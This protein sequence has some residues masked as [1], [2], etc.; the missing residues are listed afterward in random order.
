MKKTDYTAVTM[1]L[2]RAEKYLPANFKKKMETARTDLV[3]LRDKTTMLF[4]QAEEYE[5]SWNTLKPLYEFIYNEAVAENARYKIDLK[6][7]SIVFPTE[8]IEDKTRYATVC[9]YMCMAVSYC[10]SLLLDQHEQVDLQGVISLVDE[11]SAQLSSTPVPSIGITDHIAN[12]TKL[13]SDEYDPFPESEKGKQV[14]RRSGSSS[15]VIL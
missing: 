15:S 2:I 12:I 4:R 14:A 6:V 3:L 8:T 1:S 10:K 7:P 9:I 11:Y 5:T 13:F